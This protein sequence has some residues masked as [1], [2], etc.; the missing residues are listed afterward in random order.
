MKTLKNIIIFLSFLFFGSIIIGLI[1][2]LLQDAELR[3]NPT[4][5]SAIV[6]KKI[7]SSRGQHRVKYEFVVNDQIFVGNKGYMAHRQFVDIGDTLVVVFV[8][9]KPHIN[10]ILKDE[11]RFLIFYRDFQPLPQ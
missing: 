2:V 7:V 11:N 4:Y 8:E 1:V 5:G 9:D 6:T 10:K 3:K